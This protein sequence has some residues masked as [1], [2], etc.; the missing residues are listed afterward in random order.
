MESLTWIKPDERDNYKLLKDFEN[1]NIGVRLGN[2]H[3]VVDDTDHML[4]ICQYCH[5]P[6]QVK[7]KSFKGVKGSEI[8]I[9]T[10]CI[11]S[12]KACK[13]AS[14]SWVTYRRIMTQRK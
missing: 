4:L 10:R 13:C 2:A 14:K 7:T 11:N 8:I 6:K 9:L 5:N 1:T 12:K 3:I